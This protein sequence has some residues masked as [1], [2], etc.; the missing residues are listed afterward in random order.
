MAL[1]L[2]MCGLLSLAG[3]SLAQAAARA[4]AQA[5]VVRVYLAPNATTDQVAALEQRFQNDQ[6]VAS[7]RYVSA[8]EALQ[9]ASGRPGLSTLAGLSDTN[10]F[11]ASLD[12]KVKL[13]TEVS[14]VANLAGGDPAVDPAYPTSY[15]PDVYKRLRNLA[16]GAG[17]V[18]GT[19]IL[20]F[21]FVAYAVTANSMLTC[22]SQGRAGAFCWWPFFLPSMSPCCCPSLPEM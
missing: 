20:L 16:V 9:E 19:L 21:G 11:P 18:G 22:S 7:I 6:R 3:I 5:S 13:V 14:A 4:E 2:V 15:D 1:L 12:V 10:P 8:E 17:L